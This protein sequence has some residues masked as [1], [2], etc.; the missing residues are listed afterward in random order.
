MLKEGDL[1]KFNITLLSSWEIVKVYGIVC[2]DWCLN[3]NL[4]PRVWY[5]NHVY[6]ILNTGG[7]E[8]IC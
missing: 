3:S 2:E 1:V 4:R 5:K 8:K 6:E 7:I